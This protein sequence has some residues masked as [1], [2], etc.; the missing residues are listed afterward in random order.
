MAN[1]RD[2]TNE[3]QIKKATNS[4]LGLVKGGKDI[5]IDDQGQMEVMNGYGGPF[6]VSVS[7]TTATID[8]GRIHNGLEPQHIIIPVASSTIAITQGTLNAIWI[9][10]NQNGN[11]SYMRTNN[12]NAGPEVT[13][14]GT[15]TCI[16]LA[17]IGYDN[18]VPIV[19]QCNYGDI[20]INGTYY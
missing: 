6:K 1:L 2:F 20:V 7:G 17:L 14:E 4:T 3:T 11:S 18:N 12:I 19:Q 16:L 10:I 9:V 13:G 15:F 8:S 5:Y